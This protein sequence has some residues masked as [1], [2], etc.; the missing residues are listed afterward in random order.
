MFP[1]SGQACKFLTVN[2]VPVPVRIEDVSQDLVGVPSRPPTWQPSSAPDVSTAPHTMGCSTASAVADNDSGIPFKQFTSQ[3]VGTTHG[4]TIRGSTLIPQPSQQG[5]IIREESTS[6][7]EA[8]RD[9]HIAAHQHR[10]KMF[11]PEPTRSARM[12]FPK[13]CDIY[14]KIKATA[15][16]NCFAAKIPLDSDLVIPEWRKELA[17]YHDKLLC[18]YLEF[19]WPLGYHG[20]VSP[21]TTTKNHPS[22]EAHIEQI[23]DFIKKELSHRA[24]LG[25]FSED[26]FYPWVRYSPIMTREK[27]E[28][29][30]RRVILDLSYPKGSAVNDGI[31]TDNHFGQD[32]SY[33][34]PTI[35]DF[36]SRL[37]S[38]G[39]GAFMWKMDL[40]RAY[41]QLRADPL[42]APFLAMRVGTDCYIDLCPPFGCR[43]S[44]AICQKMANALVYIMGKKGFHL[45]AYLDD[46][47][48]CYKSK[49]QANDSYKAFLDLAKK[50]GLTL[51]EEKSVPPTHRMEWLGYTVDS[52]QMSITIPQ[53]KLQEV[54]QDCRA[55]LNKSRVNKKTVQ[56]IV[57]RLVYISNCVLPGRKFISRIIGTLRGMGDNQWTTLTKDFKADLRWF[58]AYAESA[59]GKFLI[60]PSRPQFDI[61][62]D[63]SLLGAGG[64]SDSQYYQWV[65]ATDHL[66]TFPA[67]HHL[68]AINVVVAIKTLTPWPHAPLDVV[69]W[70]DNSASA[71]AL[72]TG[73]TKDPILGACAREIWLLASLM[74]HNLTIRHKAGTDIP[75]ADALSRAAHNPNKAK[76]AAEILRKRPLTRTDPVLNNYVF[77]SSFL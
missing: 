15:R 48:A 6:V 25:P 2:H 47:G 17:Q 18:D 41:R 40:R 34:L 70:T 52:N 7:P 37:V 43:S 61:E 3:P 53:K 33:T 77:F 74:N 67:I 26:P 60:N 59:N 50:L 31:T 66:K 58:A 36:A 23:K 21:E 45:L 39:A 27:R 5:P 62:C 71:W 72:Q 8:T 46:F 13:F 75:L 29:D 28:S 4:R 44:A 76:L 38:Q 57:G 20:D 16:P 54:L 30:Q 65:F 73:R 51:A 69:V 11:W 35:K 49:Q 22:G 64:N 19:G 1:L 10:I 24:V 55:W 63:A 14:S 42:D 12:L 32:I 56:A 9:E 68:E